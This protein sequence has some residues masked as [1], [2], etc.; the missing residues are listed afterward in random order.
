MDVENYA[1]YIV[2]EIIIGNA[3][4]GNIR[5]FT[6]EGGKWRWMMYDTDHGFRSVSHDTVEAHLNPAGTG[7]SDMFST[8][9]I[10]SLLKNPEFK[11]MFL[12]EIAY[13]I[14]NVWTPDVVNG[15]IDE[16]AGYV[17][18]DIARDCVRWE[19]SYSSWENSVESLYTFIEGREGY[20][21]SYVKS[22]FH[23]SDS[24]MRE[25]GFNV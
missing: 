22:W 18:G 4:N 17:A 25:Y 16:F 20:I 12:E 13:Q 6:Y 10:N 21:N 9:L 2:A 23:L 14:Q 15:Y 19:H 8:K 3:D 7:A 5:F 11:K 1:D 24:E